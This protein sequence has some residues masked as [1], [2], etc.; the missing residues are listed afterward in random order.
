MFAGHATAPLSLAR[1]RS[2]ACAGSLALGGLLLLAGCGQPPSFELSWRIGEPSWRIGDPLDDAPPL[3]AVKQCSD[4]GIFLVRVTISLGD[5]VIWV[6]EQPC[7]SIVEAPPLEPGEYQ[8]E[9]EGLRRNG[10]P[11]A[12]D[13][14]VD[15]ATDRIAYASSTV[16]VSDGVLPSIE[17]ALRPPL[18]CDDGIDNDVDGTVDGQDPGCEIDNLQAPS[19]FNDVDVTLFVLEVS[20]LDS[21]AVRPYN[22]NVQSI[23]FEVDGELLAQV[24]NNQLD[25][26]Q[27]QFPLPLLAGEFDVGDHVL[28]ATAI[29]QNGALTQTQTLDFTTVDDQGAYVVGVFDFGSEMFLEPIVEPLEFLFDPGC[30]AGGKLLLQTMRVRILNEE[31]EP[32]PLDTLAG[33]TNVGGVTMP[34]S[35][36]LEGPDMGGWYTFGCPSSTVTSDPLPWGS[37][38]IEAQARLAGVSCFETPIIE[39]APQ[40]VSAQTITLE[41]VMIDGQPACPDCSTNLDCVMMAKTTCIDGL[42]VPKDGP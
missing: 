5:A 13:P 26:T 14:A 11:W 35:E 22:V 21:P 36:T 40:P 32:L 10:E 23:R 41:R 3:T 19:E 28:S 12:F 17:V 42:C 6:D 24:A 18:E 15:L 16:V 31:T 27:W 8:I 34:I 37:Y 20:F 25:Y 4:V 38:S 30:S 39:L 33:N 29:G 9:V 2:L 1:A 7:F